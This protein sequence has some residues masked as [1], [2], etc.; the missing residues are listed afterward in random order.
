[1]S[2]GIFIIF[3]RSLG[4]KRAALSPSPL[5]LYPPLPSLPL[6]S[7]YPSLPPCLPRQYKRM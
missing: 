2:G 1:M 4:N 5:P 3:V 6:P 7:N